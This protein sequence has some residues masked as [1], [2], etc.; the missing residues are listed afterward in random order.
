MASELLERGADPNKKVGAGGFT[1]LHSAVLQ[2]RLKLVEELLRKNAN[3]EATYDCGR[4]PLLTAV[5]YHA[6]EDMIKLLLQEGKNACAHCHG[7]WEMY[8]QCVACSEC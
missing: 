5:T 3:L 8:L 2:G 7:R 1:P 6:S 4:T